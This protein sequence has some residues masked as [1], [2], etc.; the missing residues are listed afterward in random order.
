MGR[1]TAST[2]ILCLTLAAC[3]DAAS[4]APV[5][6][7]PGLYDLSSSGIVLESGGER[8]EKCFDAS[9]A[10]EFSLSPLRQAIGRWR[11]CSDTPEP[12]QGNATSGKRFCKGASFRDDDESIYTYTAETSTD[13]FVI[14][15]ETKDK[16]D[17][18]GPDTGRWRVM[19]HRKGDC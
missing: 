3:R 17:G 18:S 9:E 19:A 12:R 14:E 11:D 10:R 1:F 8:H 6:L 4:E 15:G 2:I 16:E 7:Q 5:D 13:G